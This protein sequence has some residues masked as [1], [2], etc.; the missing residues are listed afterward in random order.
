MF[1]QNTYV[2]RRKQLGK[3]LGKGLIL[4]LGNSDSSMNFKDNLYHFRQDSTFLYYVGIDQPNLACVIDV[5]KGTTTLFGNKASMDAIIWTGAITSLDSLAEKSGI[6]SVLPLSSLE[7]IVKANASQAVHYLPPYRPE[8]KI[9][10]AALLGISIEE[11]PVKASVGLIKAVVQQRSIKSAEELLQIEEAVNTSGQMHLE[12]IRLGQPGITETY[13]AGIIQGIAVSGGGDLSFPSIVTQNG[14]YLHNHASMNALEDGKLLLV[15]AGAE[16][17]MHYAGDITRTSPVGKKFS[18][19]QREMY[20]IVLDA[21]LAAIAALK[22]GITYKEVHTIAATHLVSG[23]IAQGVMKGD[24]AEAVAN[25]AHTLFFQCGLGHMMGL[26]VHDMENLG[27]QYVGYTDEMKKGTAF[28]WKSLRLGK[29]LE[30]GF[31]ITVEPG[32]YFIPELMDAWKSEGK[33]EQ[34]INYDAAFK[35]KDFGGIRIEDD[36]LITESGSRLLGKPIP[37]KIEEIEDLKQ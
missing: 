21:Q 4:L 5:E 23:L 25:D 26:D 32:L 18:A 2:E 17:H 35:L 30:P 14:Q 19:L 28:G 20:Q 8:Q 33:L 24:A 6:T 22:P 1:S 9:Q 27:E 36:F 7:S 37:K 31:V 10:L 15:D 13:I 3:S 11:T 29:A 12:A 34:F 16:N